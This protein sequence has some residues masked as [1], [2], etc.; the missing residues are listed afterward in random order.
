MTTDARAGTDVLDALSV[1]V[2]IGPAETAH[3]GLLVQLREL[4]PGCERILVPALGAIAPLHAP[5]C[6]VSPA[7][8]G[9]ARQLNHGAGLATRHWLWFLH[10]DSRFVPDTLPALRRFVSRS[11]PALGYFEL[12]FVDGPAAT[13][14]NQAGAWLRS[15]LLGL[16]FG[17]QGLVLPRALF[18]RIGPFDETVD[19]G[20]DHLL[21]WD[22]HFAGVPVRPVGAPLHSSARR[23]AEHGWLRT[24]AR[25]L[26][27]TLR[28]MAQARRRR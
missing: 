23:Y 13:R 7:P 14:I 27:L 9:R 16:P 25:H 11:P 15:H 20:E 5:D 17:D 19:R 8:R 6:L 24:T 22:A 3:E 28:Q 2:P 21:V 12:R 18:E 4:P 1:I 26:L 10:A